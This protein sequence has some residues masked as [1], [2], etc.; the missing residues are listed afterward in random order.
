[1]INILNRNIKILKNADLYNLDHDQDLC[2][3]ICFQASR[4]NSFFDK[5]N[6]IKLLYLD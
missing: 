3:K 1:M 2:G 5:S 6:I 4:V